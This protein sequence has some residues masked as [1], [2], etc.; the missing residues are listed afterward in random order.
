ME[1]PLGPA[2]SPART[3]RVT[4]M[5]CELQTLPGRAHVRCPAA[6]Q[7]GAQRLRRPCGSGAVGRAVTKTFTVSAADQLSVQLRGPASPGPL[8]NAIEIVAP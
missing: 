7:A 3:L 6:R 2:G 8:I 4:L 1:I 5:F